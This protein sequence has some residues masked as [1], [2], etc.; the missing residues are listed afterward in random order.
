MASRAPGLSW[1]ASCDLPMSLTAG[2]AEAVDKA[3]EE[4]VYSDMRARTPGIGLGRAGGASDRGPGARLTRVL[5]KWSPSWGGYHL[6]YP[7]RR[8]SSPAFLAVV[9]SLRYRT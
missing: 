6:Y 8:Q 7:S 9:G 1:P 3:R 2:S 4:E 5:E